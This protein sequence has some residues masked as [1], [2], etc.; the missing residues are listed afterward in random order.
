VG[1]EE[2]ERE[3]CGRSGKVV[4]ERSGQ[5]Q[6]VERGRR[7]VMSRNITGHSGGHRWC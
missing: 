2:G 5:R 4:R 3:E 6:Q 7:K 1:D